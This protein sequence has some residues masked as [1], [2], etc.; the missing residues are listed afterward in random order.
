[1]SLLKRHR[2]PAEA[3]TELSRLIVEHRDT[4]DSGQL[5]RALARS[6][7]HV[8]MP[9]APAE[10][11][12]RVE[13]S[14]GTDGAPLY[15]VEDE[16]GR[17][18]LV[19]T[20]ARRLVESAGAVTA[21]TIP[22]TTLLM[23]WPA[24]VDLVLDPGHPEALEVPV[25]LLQAT[26]LEAAGVPSGT[27]LQP[28][29]AGVEARRPEPEPVQVLGVTRAVAETLDEVLAL[30]RAELVNREP[31]AR[32]VLHLVVTLAAVDDER[33]GQV[34]TA[35][36]S[37]VGEVDPNPVAMLP[38]QDGKASSHQ[39][40]VEAVIGVDEPYWQRSDRAH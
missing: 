39:D 36:V 10:P 9:G 22:F 37:A 34:M 15:V 17:H 30:H 29:P 1:M 18:A 5:V 4:L 2:Q 25:E 26:A 12:P 21:A 14:A 6:V 8:P 33:L 20:T 16:D 24:G 19:F 31:G 35:L 27:G 7:V 40:L 32:P 13:S 38:V 3:A 23:G 11:R 28:A